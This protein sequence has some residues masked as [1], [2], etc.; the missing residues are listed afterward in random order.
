MKVKFHT[1]FDG[2]RRHSQK[3]RSSKNTIHYSRILSRHGVSGV[4]PG[5]GVTYKP[6]LIA[7]GLS[8]RPC[9]KY[10]EMYSLVLD[11]ITFLI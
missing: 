7:Q 11:V 4:T 2:S 5:S 1:L 8:Q 3:C 6:R 9:I 10:E